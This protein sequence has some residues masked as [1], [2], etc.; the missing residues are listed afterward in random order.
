MNITDEMRRGFLEIVFFDR[1]ETRLRSGGVFSERCPGLRGPPARARLAMPRRFAH[2]NGLAPAPSSTVPRPAPKRL[3]PT[4]FDVFFGVSACAFVLL[5]VA[6]G[7]RDATRWCRDE[8]ERKKRRRA[9]RARRAGATNAP[10]LS[11]ASSGGERER[12]GANARG[13]DGEESGAR[14]G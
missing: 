7:C 8:R 9:R 1:A 5:V 2:A 6:L 13:D 10:L 11:P 3:P 12:A 14:G 4:A